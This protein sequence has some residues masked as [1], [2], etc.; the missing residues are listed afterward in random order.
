[1]ELTHPVHCDEQHGVQ[2]RL[3]GQLA[4]DH[5]EGIITW[6]PL[7]NPHRARH[8]LSLVDT[9]GRSA[10]EL[11][12]WAE[13]LPCS[14][15]TRDFMHAHHQAIF[16]ADALHLPPELRS[17]YTAA[18]V[19][20]YDTIGDRRREELLQAAASR[21]WTMSHMMLRSDLESIARGTE[22]YDG[23]GKTVRRQC[24]KNLAR[25]I[26]DRS[27]RINLAVADDE[28][29][30]QLFQGFD[31]L[32]VFDEGFAFWRSYSGDIAY[33]THPSIVRLR[34]T[35]LEI[36][37]SHAGHRETEAVLE[38]LEGLAARMS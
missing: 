9:Y 17:E 22:P 20:M 33:T 35:L 30:R 36:L 4:G 28:G 13:F 38:L 19:S 8:F 3:D 18:V 32:V 21:Q 37:R 24:L 29:M 31:S 7:T 10:K 34:R 23:I 26:T 16:D 15:E 2:F 1:M 11:L 25:L 6:D 14:L 5:A 27:L 12:A